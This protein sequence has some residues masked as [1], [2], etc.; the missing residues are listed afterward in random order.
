M[1]YLNPT[2]S[3]DYRACNNFNIKVF[4]KVKTLKYGLAMAE[5]IG[6]WIII[7]AIFSFFVIIAIVAAVSSGRNSRSARTGTTWTAT[8]TIQP[9]QL[10]S[11]TSGLSSLQTTKFYHGTK[12]EKAVEIYSTGLWL[13]G[14]SRK[15]WITDNFTIAKGYAGNNGGIVLINAS[16]E[17]QLKNHGGGVYTYH[18]PNA[19]PFQEYY[20]I[21]GLTPIGV[22]SPQ[23]HRIR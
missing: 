14:H 3:V 22:L 9:I 5:Y 4:R 16:R 8:P 20:Q 11:Y 18:I 19:K 1:D 21:E 2:G 12:L 6:A 23:G 13:I 17:V 15:L 7:L 10:P